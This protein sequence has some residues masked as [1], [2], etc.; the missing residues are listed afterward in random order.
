MPEPFKNLFSRKVINHMGDHFVRAWAEFPRDEFV[1][2]A[3]ERLDDLE[4]KQ[5]SEQIVR[6]MLAF[7]PA[8]F[9]TAAGIMLESLAPESHVRKKEESICPDGI[10]GWAIMPM[11]YYVGLR[12]TG[13]FDLS[14]R[15]MREMTKRFTAEFGI[16]LLTIAEPERSLAQFAEWVDD[17]S[18][19][20]RRLVSEGTRPRLPWAM[21]LARLVE[22]PTPMLPLLEALR[23]DKSEYVRRS[24]ANHLNDISKDHPDLLAGVAAEWV[25]G[26]V[27]SERQRLTPKVF[28]WKTLSLAGGGSLVAR[29]RHP[30]REI[31]TRKYYPEL[32]RLEILVNGRSLAIADFELHKS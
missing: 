21:R 23:D 7:L 28:K 31:S 26:E 30:I 19:H 32:H 3:S 29:R 27:P 13:H 14:M 1:A 18:E 9:E 22:D 5:R 24:V 25:K 8:D 20:V 6:A 15:L 17:P 4:L 2:A 12:G 16:R 11:T 10:S